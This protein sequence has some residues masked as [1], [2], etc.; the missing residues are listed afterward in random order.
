MISE[1]AIT[2]RNVD[3]RA[4][5]TPL[6]YRMCGDDVLLAP[7]VPS[8]TLDN[9][10]RHPFAV[11]NFTDDVRVIAGPLTG[12]RAWP[13]V[14]ATQV[15]V[16]RLADSLAHWEMEAVACTEDVTRPVFTCRVRHRAMHS[17]FLGF[18]RAQ[19]A[20]VELAVLVSRLDWLPPEKVRHELAY[21]RI[22]VEKTAG[23]REWEAWRW[24]EQA[25]VRHP[26]H[27]PE[28]ALE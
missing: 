17:P 5:V 3:G 14:A 2:T 13:C 20:V 28:G 27:V 8:R 4:H 18:N 22:A 19:A 9:L 1:A 21:L 7:F 12:H 26:R 24:L 25:V 16:P 23:P 11:L 10:R 6:G 15:D